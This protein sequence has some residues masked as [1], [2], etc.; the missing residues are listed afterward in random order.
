MG[1]MK[2]ALIEAEVERMEKI[3]GKLENASDEAKQTGLGS[4]LKK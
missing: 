2:T 1:M 3:I 4:W